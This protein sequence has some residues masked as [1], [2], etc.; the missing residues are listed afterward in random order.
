MPALPKRFPRR[1]L[2][3]W[4]NPLKLMMKRKLATM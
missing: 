2:A 3:G 4:L 1:E